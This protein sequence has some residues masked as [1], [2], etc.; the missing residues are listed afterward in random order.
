MK[1]NSKY[2]WMTKNK[3]IDFSIKYPAFFLGIIS[4]KYPFTKT[5]LR[6]Y[7]YTLDWEKV[8]NNEN[9]LWSH[10]I[11]TELKDLFHWDFLSV[12]RNVFKDLS[13]LD[14]F[15]DKIDWSGGDCYGDSIAANEG[16]YWDI[17]LIG[18]YAD[19]LNFEKLSYSTN[20]EWSELLLEKHKDKWDYDE[21]IL[22]ESIPWTL[23]LFD[24]YFDKSTLLKIHV[25]SNT[26][27]MTFDLIQKYYHLI[28]WHTICSNPN[29]PWIE[30][31]LLELWSERIFWS[32]I[33][34][35]PFFIQNNEY[36]QKYSHKWQIHKKETKS[37]LA[38]NH[39]FQW[40]KETIEK[41]KFELDWSVLCSNNSIVWDINLIESFSKYVVW[42]G[43]KDGELY[44]GQGEV[45]SPFGGKEYCWGL[46]ENIS[47][48]WSIDFILHFEDK[49]ELEALESN[50]AV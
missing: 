33:V 24:K 8:S 25:Q 3:I 30:K 19:K 10:E 32:K 15:E 18:K 22:N 49:L 1:C 27:L 2:D 44:N 50:P 11:L 40:T 39:E 4:S 36:C 29:L 42:G 38:W 35:N 45:V 46:I 7:A 34:D 37:S 21:L 5:Q 47:I 16:I 13:L 48:P 41:L 23:E 9:I 26:R 12:N 14:A 31:N 28:N 6:K 20:V 17:E 43:W